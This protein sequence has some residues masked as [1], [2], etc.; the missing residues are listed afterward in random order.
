M[1][2]YTGGCHCGAVTYEVDI[3]NLTE[4]ME[5]NCSHC[6]K[7]GFLLYFAPKENFRLLSGQDNLTSYKFGKKVIDH[8]FCKTCGVE[9]FSSSDAYPKMMI[10]VRCL[11]NVDLDSLKINKYN[12]RTL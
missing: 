11:D 3:E 6:E 9:S 10:N 8:V 2:T 12:G 7:K 4:V 1:Q 5:C